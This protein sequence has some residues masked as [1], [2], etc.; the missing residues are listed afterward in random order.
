MSKIDGYQEMFDQVKSNVKI[1]P[2]N[3]RKSPG[4]FVKGAAA[5]AICLLAGGTVVSY[6]FNLFDIRSYLWEEKMDI[7]VAE[8]ESEE[9][10]R[11]VDVM[12]FQPMGSNEYKA[13][14]EWLA[15]TEEIENSE[16]FWET[17]WEEDE[18][19]QKKYEAYSV[20]TREMGDKLEEIAENYNLSL[21]S[22]MKMVES[23]EELYQM[24]GTAEFL[25]ED[26]IL[27][28]GYIF[29]DGTFQYDGD[30]KLDGD[31]ILSFQFRNSAQGSLDPVILTIGEAE[32]YTERVFE[33]SAGKTVNIAASE[34]KIIVSVPL[35][36]STVTI[37]I[38]KDLSIRQAELE[39]VEAAAEDEQK[40]AVEFTEDDI[41][42]LINSIDFEMLNN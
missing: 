35:E 27:L 34:D 14:S 23:K 37:N 10:T 4:R 8:E 29:D 12:L 33:T 17:E 38:L 21:L 42:T 36:N 39:Q 24:A 13:T 15:Y 25:G 9:T 32:N 11:A 19:F 22:G 5:A 1:N 31:R 2:A 26:N 28:G 7:T 20:F 6:A 30:M 18:A 40:E 16:N 3:Y 41:E